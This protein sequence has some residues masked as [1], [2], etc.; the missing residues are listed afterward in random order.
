MT[1][2]QSTILTEIADLDPARGEP[3]ASPEQAD[4]T[5]RWVLAH[6]RAEPAADTAHPRF[7]R[8]TLVS[9]AAAVVVGVFAATV[10]PGVISGAPTRAAATVPMLI[11]AEPEGT[12]ARAELERLAEKAR[13]SAPQDAM[14]G[15][16][17]YLREATEEWIFPE[18]YGLT[19]P[20]RRLTRGTER[21][22]APDRSVRE[23]LTRNGLV[24]GGY[25]DYSRPLGAPLDVS[26]TPEEFLRRVARGRPTDEIISMLLSV[27]SATV[28]YHGQLPPAER[29]TYLEALATTDVVSYGAVTD[30]AGRPGIA[31]G[32]TE[33]YEYIPPDPEMADKFPSTP[34]LDGSTDDFRIILDPETGELLGTE[35]I[36]TGDDHRPLD[37]VTGHSTFLED[38]YV[39]ALPECGAIYCSLHE[40]DPWPMLGEPATDDPA[41]LGIDLAPLDRKQAFTDLLHDAGPVADLSV[42]PASTRYVTSTEGRLYWVGLT[43]NP[44]ADPPTEPQVCL[45]L[46]VV[47]LADTAAACSAVE[48]FTADG[49]ELT[50][51]GDRVLLVPDTHDLPGSG[52]ARLSPN[53]YLKELGADHAEADR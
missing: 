48:R 46:E 21:W 23:L 9:A 15:Q 31:F 43:H 44:A 1:A 50:Y 20:P 37:T 12:D 2:T 10:L 4:E 41:A 6:D 35:H 51:Q 18:D 34:D 32:V 25:Q 52:W 22:I 3:L 27:Y 28:S 49:I 19:G 53:L 33:H 39:D 47:D 24:D 8:A 7:R 30:R 17:R 38:S 40:Q 36:T 11:Y 45:I 14:P 26:G 42:D 5:L 16:Y 29:A 13:T